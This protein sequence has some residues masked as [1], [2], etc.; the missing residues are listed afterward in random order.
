MEN[1]LLLSMLSGAGA[2][3][4]GPDSFAANMNPMVQQ[5]IAAQSKATT[6]QK[7]MKWLQDLISGGAK[8]SMDKDKFSIGG[9]TSVLQGMLKGDESGGGLNASVTA[10]TPSAP[11]P[12]P[13]DPSGV[14]NLNPSIS[15]PVLSRADLAGL[16]PQDVSQAL[17]GAINVESLMQSKISDVAN[18]DL[19]ER[20]LALTKRLT[21]AQI[22]KLGAETSGLTPSINIPGTD[23][24]LT[25]SQ[26]IEWWKAAT[27]D[28]RT[29]AVKNFEYAQVRGFKGSFEQFQDLSSTTHKKDY[30]TAVKG[31]YKGEFNEWMLEMAKAGA[32]NL[33]DIVERKKATEDIEAQKYFT[34]PKGLAADV[35]KHISSDEVQ[36]RLI[37]F[38][39]DPRKLKMETVRSSEE[40]IVGKI[41]GSGGKIIEQKLEGRTFVWKVKWPDGTTSEVRHA[42]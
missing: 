7:Y 5:N 36:N 4:A 21:E 38:S 8:V 10:P 39:N 35:S 1:N 15:P 24:K 27:K 33:G 41:T 13:V 16:T 30:D 18:R 23:I 37:R 3:V 2:A 26:Y 31:G 14:M 34:N 20:E 11:A 19:K 9:E 25:G 28:E 32:I 40:Y 6:Q 29:A 42:N 22:G 12:A 17:A